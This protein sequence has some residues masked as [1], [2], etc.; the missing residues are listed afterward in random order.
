MHEILLTYGFL[1]L[2]CI[3]VVEIILTLILYGD[4]SKKKDPVVI[5]MAL[6][7]TGLCFDAVILAAGGYIMIPILSLLSRARYILHG[8]L[9]PLNLA[10]CAYAAPFYKPARHVTWVL[11]VLLMLAGAAA[12]FMRELDKVVLNEGFYNQIVRY[13]SVSPKDSWME[14][15]NMGLSVGCIVPIILTG[16][17]ITFKHKTPTILLAGLFMLGFSL[18]GP[19]TGNTDLIFLISMFGEMFMLL[20]YVIFEKKHISVMYDYSDLSYGSIR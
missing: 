15:V 11:T 3:S 8:L 12:G 4:F 19:L 20:F 6:V 14:R 1:I 7:G 16:I 10:I 9:I 5:L 17:Y 2:C 18:L 13:V